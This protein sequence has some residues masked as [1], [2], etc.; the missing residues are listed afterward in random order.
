[1]KSLFTL[2][3]VFAMLSGYSQTAP[4]FTVTDVNGQSHNLYTDYL[5][6]NT[7]VVL[8][9]FFV[10][11]PPCNTAA[12]HFQN[13]Y[14]FW[15]E[16]Q[17]NVQFMDLSNKVSDNN[18]LVLGYKNQ[19][20]L[21]MPTVG[22]QGGSV[23]AQALYT[24]GTFGPF[25]GTPHY[26]VIAPDKTVHYDVSLNEIDQIIMDIQ[27]NMGAPGIPVTINH[28]QGAMLPNGIAIMM[29]PKNAPSPI[30]NITA[31][32]SG[33]HSFTYPSSDFP[34]IED[35]IVYLE[36]TAGAFTHDLRAGDLIP[37]RKHILGLETFDDPRL[38]I[39][40]DVNGDNK[41]RANDL[42]EIRKV[43]LGLT[44]H[45]PNNVPSYVLYPETTDLDSG[46]NNSIELNLDIIKKGN[47][48]D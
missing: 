33:S 4:N 27:G 46:G 17:Q 10:N 26:T 7:I 41:I 22:A 42:V 18:T 19:H 15:G 45:F 40:A 38:E 44:I 6:Q 31:K 11:C 12:P 23:Q 29:K 24:S 8:K 3:L 48:I 28:N 30:Y 9:V 35:P 16:G 47:I 20:G 25:F 37:I 14:E 2:F 5:D 32:T 36:S 34:E 39:A 1:M 43:I 13:K 21:T